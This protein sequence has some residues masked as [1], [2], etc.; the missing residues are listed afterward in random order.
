MWPGA[1]IPHA[2][3]SPLR[4]PR[5]KSGLL[6]ATQDKL[7]LWCQDLPVCCG[8][9]AWRA[10]L[11]ADVEGGWRGSVHS[12]PAVTERAGGGGDMPLPALPIG[13]GPGVSH[14][15]RHHKPAPVLVVTSE[16]R[17]QGAQLHARHV[18]P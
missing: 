1:H 7:G 8:L 12:S 16:P 9:W 5:V 11:K 18:V 17:C 2:L 3:C 6:A 4:A 10:F 13:L 15:S 14:P